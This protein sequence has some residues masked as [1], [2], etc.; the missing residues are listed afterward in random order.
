MKIRAGNGCRPLLALVPGF[1]AAWA[2]LAAQAQTQDQIQEVVV[3]AQKRSEN[4]QDVPIAVTAISSAQL[5]QKGINSVSQLSNIAP[6]VNLDAG[7]PFSGSDT[8][9][10]AYI[11]GSVQDDFAL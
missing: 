2:A 9:L 6:N 3:T 7:T 11:R 10:S 1:L 4:I 8:V 5:E